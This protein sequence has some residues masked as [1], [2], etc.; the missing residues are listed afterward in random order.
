MELT[1]PRYRNQIFKLEIKADHFPKYPKIN[2]P[3]IKFDSSPYASG[4]E[5]NKIK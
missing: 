5:A 4:G 3:T 2:L 1:F